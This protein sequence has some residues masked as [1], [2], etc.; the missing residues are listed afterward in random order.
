MSDTADTIAR[1]ITLAAGR[2][3]HGS[4][5]VDSVRRQL[6]DALRPHFSPA[7]CPYGNACLAPLCPDSHPTAKPPVSDVDTPAQH[8]AWATNLLGQMSRQGLR[9]GQTY[10]VEE[11]LSHLRRAAE[12]DEPPAE[13]HAHTVDGLLYEHTHAP[14]EPHEDTREH[15]RAHRP[16]GATADQLDATLLRGRTCLEGGMHAGWAGICDACGSS[17]WAELAETVDQPPEA[18]PE[19]PATVSEAV[20]DMARRISRSPL[21]HS[22]LGVK[23]AVA[24]LAEGDDDNSDRATMEADFRF[25]VLREADRE[26]VEANRERFGDYGTGREL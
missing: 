26:D 25:N 13:R 8:I 18:R 22:T 20:R 2:M 6:A 9:A 16:A 1:A 17:V 12:M 3:A 24:V 23:L 19:P 7:P 11:A 21:E 5:D 15:L 10:A 14:Q 4:A